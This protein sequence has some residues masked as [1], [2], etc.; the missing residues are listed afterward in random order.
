MKRII[1]L[2]IMVIILLVGS[3]SYAMDRNSVIAVMDFGTRPGASEKEISLNQAEHITSEYVIDRLVNDNCFQVVEKD[4]VMKQIKQANIKTVGL[5]DPDTAKSIGEM[6]KVKYIFYGNITNV[7]L[8]DVGTS[9]GGTGLT[10][11]TVKAHIVGRVM[12]VDSGNIIYMVKG[13]GKS[14][15]TFT[16]VPGVLAGT[17]SFGTYKVTQDSVHNAIQK[18]AYAMVD[19]LNKRIK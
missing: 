4:F 18:A 7:S 15:S 8:S 11:S 5:I 6:L 10:K 12:D 19:E 2:L 9:I 14:A 1:L 3:T 13:D 16:K 17:I